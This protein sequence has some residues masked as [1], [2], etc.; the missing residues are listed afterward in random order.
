MTK[1][2][3][4]I[5][6]ALFAFLG[7]SNAMA[8]NVA[9]I[10]DTE[11]ETLAAAFTAVTDG[12]TI[13]MIT[14]YSM[15][16]SSIKIGAS[17]AKNDR[18]ITLDLNGHTLTG[19]GASS[20]FL[21]YDKFT[22]TDS[23]D[24]TPGVINSA[25]SGGVN[26]L[27]YVYGTMIM[28]KVT[29]N[30]KSD[31][32]NMLITTASG[33]SF[34]MNSGTINQPY[35]RNG[36]INVYSGVTVTINGGT[37]N[38][39]YPANSSTIESSGNAIYV[40]NGTLNVNGG[41]INSNQ[42]GIY[43]N[44]GTVNVS[45]GTLAA[46]NPVVVVDATLNATGGEYV[47][48]DNA[49]YVLSTTTAAAI[50]ISGGKYQTSGNATYLLNSQDN[51][52]DKVT[53]AII[54]GSYKE[55]DPANNEADG[56]GTN[57]VAD[58]YLTWS[59][60]I[61][62]AAWYHVIENAATMAYY[63]G[64]STKVEAADPVKAAEWQAIL[65]TTPN[66]VAIVA[67][68][69]PS[70]A[71]ANANTNVLIQNGDTYTCPN[72]VLTEYEEGVTSTVDFY[73]PANFTAE[74]LS[75]SRSNTGGYNSVCLPFAIA[76]ADVNNSSIL[77]YKS[78]NEDKTS[79]TLSEASDVAAGTPCFVRCSSDDAGWNISKT[80]VEVVATVDNTNAMKGSCADTQIGAGY[81]KLN[82]AGTQLCL[83]TD[84]A[85]CY[86]FRSYIQVPTANGAKTIDVVLSD[87]AV[88][89]IDAVSSTSDVEAIYNVNGV[90][91]KNV[92]KGL[93][94]VKAAD[95]SVRKIMVK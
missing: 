74:K 10:G 61:D 41:T 25:C 44:S 91:L 29:L 6:L 70:A 56:K 68:D 73:T 2:F 4:S 5:L 85:W 93:N 53:W 81:Y 72:F 83:T 9:K 40:S 8:D 14:D 26:A 92:Q 82:S 94:I 24:A 79:V 75:Y 38:N 7:V 43:A 87:D 86:A 54:G 67:N 30:G 3:N 11:Y 17:T 80:N 12:Q 22:L 62:G 78:I 52:K 63:A 23:N 15:P 90:L 36:C 76:S 84:A 46:A 50:N 45:A 35:A 21:V 59:E 32:A 34:T 16:S 33:S 28:E 27:F 66:A 37:I 20:R 55:F 95:G 13:T 31:A 48:S 65:A 18:T 60:S 58:G 69:G 51:I 42:T 57:Y 89:A 1:Q 39:T 47:A 77:V 71:F 19:T 49:V 64:N 88:T